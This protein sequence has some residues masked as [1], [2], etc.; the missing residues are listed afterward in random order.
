MRMWLRPAAA[1][2]TLSALCPS[3]LPLL[4]T[5][6]SCAVHLH[7]WHIHARGAS[8][9][10][11]PPVIWMYGLSRAR[12]GRRGASHPVRHAHESTHA[13]HVPFSLL[14]DCCVLLLCYLPHVYMIMCMIMCAC[15][16][17]RV[18]LRVRCSAVSLG[19]RARATN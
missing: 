14:H 6:V 11:C 18:A 7:P 8:P 13:M 5:I 3:P 1:A 17:A 2:R 4:T 9:C 12:Q 10:M 19:F 15:V 16:S